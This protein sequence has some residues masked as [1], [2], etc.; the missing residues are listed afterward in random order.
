MSY[1][2]RN[3]NL[4]LLFL[5]VLSVTFL[6]GV[7][8]FYQN[9]YG[10]IT[11]D[12]NDKLSMLDKR[13]KEV[14]NLK[15]ILEDTRKDLELK[16]QRESEFTDKFTEIKGEK[17]QLATAK[18]QLESSKKSLE[19]QVKDQAKDLSDAKAELTYEKKASKDLESQN[20]A[21]RV[22]V[23]QDQSII[24]RLQSQISSLQSAQQPSP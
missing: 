14:D 4:V 22:R 9:N 11:T 23:S 13:Q 15:K 18:E 7:T 20:E 17:E 10:D 5:I 1:I 19:S 6:V 3:A 21:L 2:N 24:D 16:G 12:Y 8:V